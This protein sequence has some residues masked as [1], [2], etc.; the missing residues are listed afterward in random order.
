MNRYLKLVL[1]LVFVLLLNSIIYFVTDLFRNKR[2]SFNN[3]NLNY[4]NN[5]VFKRN[6]DNMNLFKNITENTANE[7]GI[8]KETY[9]TVVDVFEN[10]KSPM[11]LIEALKD[12][13]K[14]E[15]ESIQKFMLNN[16]N[17]NKNTNTNM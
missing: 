1:I 4:L 12:T 3:F 2:E 6:E 9:N 11:D 16:T 14:D 13:P 17:T 15:I 10:N 7:Y 5:T 8:S